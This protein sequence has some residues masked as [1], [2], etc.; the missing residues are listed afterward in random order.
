MWKYYLSFSL[1]AN[2]RGFSVP[3]SLGFN[4]ELG[5]AYIYASVIKYGL[6]TDLWLLELLGVY[7]HISKADSR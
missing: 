1:H 3:V 6:R 2:V 5:T 4:V 7:T